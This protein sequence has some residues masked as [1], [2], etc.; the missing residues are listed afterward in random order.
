M[1]AMFS[2][3]FAK[4]HGSISVVD[5]P[6]NSM[7]KV[8]D[9]VLVPQAVFE[10]R[11]ECPEALVKAVRDHVE[12]MTKRAYYAREEL[13]G[14]AL[15]VC[16][17]HSF[18]SEVA[19]SGH[20]GFLRKAQEDIEPRLAAV[21]FGLKTIGA[22]EHLMLARR[23][24][25]W[26]LDHA[27]H[28]PNGSAFRNGLVR[29]LDA[30][31]APFAELETHTPLIKYIADWISGQSAL[32]VIAD[33][34]FLPMRDKMAKAN[35]TRHLREAAQEIDRLN[36]MLTARPHA[37]ISLAAGA[38]QTPQPIIAVGNQTHVHIDN[39]QADAFPLKTTGGARWCVMTSGGVAIHE[40]KAHGPQRQGDTLPTVGDC[41]ASVSSV[42]ITEAVSVSR[43]LNAATAVHLLLQQ[44]PEAPKVDYV[45]VRSVGPDDAGTMGMSLLL[46]LNRATTAMSV[47]VTETDAFLLSEPDHKKIAALPAE[48]IR[49]YACKMRPDA[50]A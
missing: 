20:A 2:N 43:Q 40:Q 19:Q 47:V 37:G 6:T 44:V 18:L 16:D 17:L 46:V 24:S 28:I 14:M 3:L 42:Q 12:V 10:N 1:S 34:N 35:P 22:R 13:C 45:T 15:Q 9:H 26:V 29:S 31:D 25:Q 39:K 5:T 11:D 27:D 41:L 50:V 4:R 8:R 36:K 33:E 38:L 30:L 49:Q 23:M 32:R 48:I 7:L 21:L